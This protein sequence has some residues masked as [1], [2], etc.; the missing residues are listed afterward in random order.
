MLQKIHLTMLE[1]MEAPACVTGRGP[2]TSDPDKVT[3]KGCRGSGTMSR[4][5]MRRMREG[6]R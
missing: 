4:L 5:L 3:C 1:N 6:K 2:L